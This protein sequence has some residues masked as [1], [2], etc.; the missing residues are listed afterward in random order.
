MI[1]IVGAVVAVLGVAVEVA[2]IGASKSD[3]TGREMQRAAL[4]AMEATGGKW[5][6]LSRR[7]TDGTWGM[8][9]IRHDGTP[10][11]V[12][13]ND[14]LEVISVVSA[15]AARRTQVHFGPGTLVAP[16]KRMAHAAAAP[17]AQGDDRERAVLATDFDGPDDGENGDGGFDD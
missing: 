4:A 7:G 11:E 1:A 12:T 16:V 2:V 10:V 15:P 17:G 6:N 3:A 8:S 9:V 14:R 5:A 13:L